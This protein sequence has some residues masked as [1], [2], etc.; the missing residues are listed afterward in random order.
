MLQEAWDN[1]KSILESWEVR[2]GERKSDKKK[3]TAE[4][5]NFPNLRKNT[6]LQIQDDP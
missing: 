2:R 5:K 3:K 4:A 1:M 6:N